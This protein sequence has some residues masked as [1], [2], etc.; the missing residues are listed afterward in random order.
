[1]KETHTLPFA[2]TPDSV[3]QWLVTLETASAAEKINQVNKAVTDLLSSAD[4][5]KPLLK[6]L[7]KLL[8]PVLML[9]SI[10]ERQ[11]LAD[12]SA[13]AQE[14]S[15]KYRALSLQM[16]K[17][18]GFLYA[19]I[20]ADSALD[21][22]EQALCFYRAVQMVSLLVK[23]AT[24]FYEGPDFSL[25]KKF[26]EIYQEISKRK[27]YKVPIEN[28]VSGLVRYPSME[29]G[30]KH[31]LL[32]QTVNAY[33]LAPQEISDI[34]AATG[35]LSPLLVLDGRPSEADGFQW[36]ARGYF[37]PLSAYQDAKCE[38]TLYI[39]TEK[40]AAYLE[41]HADETVSRQLTALAWRRLTAYRDII[42]SVRPASQISCGLMVGNAQ[43]G[44][45]LTTL[46]SRYRILEL[47]GEIKAK[48]ASKKLELVPL[49]VKNAMGH[50]STKVLNDDKSLSVH[51]AKLFATE[52]RA[53]YTTKMRNA[54]FTFGEPAL[55]LSENKK[56]LFGVLRH[57]RN[58]QGVELA[59][60]LIEVINGDVYPFDGGEF[61]GFLIVETTGEIDLFLPPSA[62]LTVGTA[63]TEKGGASRSFRIEKFIE[64][65]VNFSRYRVV[66]C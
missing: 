49:E 29:S 59:N 11:S 41:S 61:Q 1:M 32:F 46:I 58:E 16:P 18:L 43:I 39:N 27:L 20:A 60:I 23:R 4:D 31:I 38:N 25:W 22:A 2:L 52:D 36:N 13:A 45:F 26:G 8:P 28:D 66:C 35:R 10:L 47:S 65:T 12:R 55:I 64:L 63:L 50:L 9:A 30:V 21:E 14:K 24:L 56:P 57:I 7:D 6:V 33:G 40:L 34:F 15:G 17:K 62:G 44:R 37:P 5:A 3:E 54:N 48:T 51:N 42:R 53:F 19:K